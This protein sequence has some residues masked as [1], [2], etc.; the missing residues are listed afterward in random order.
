MGKKKFVLVI[1]LCLA[2]LSVIAMFS[3]SLG[4]K[5]IAFSKVMEVIFGNDLDSIEATIILQRIPRTVFGIL[6]G[7]ALGISGALMQSITRNPIADP[8]ILGV[9]T[10]ASLFVVAGIAFFNITAAYQYIWLAIIGAGL[11]AVF[12]YSVA[13]MGKDGA[14]PLKLALS[15]SAVSIVLGSLVSTIMLPNNRVMEAFRFWQVGSIG[16]ATWENIALISPFMILGFIISM[17]ISGYLNNLALGDEA[18]T[19][20]GTNVVLTRS[21]GALASVLLCGAATALAGPIGFIGL[22]IPHIVRLVFGSEM[23]KM[24]P[25]SFIGSGILLLLSDILGRIIGSPGETEVGI[26][27]AVLGAPIFIFAIRKG[28]VKSL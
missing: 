3:V 4:V 15:G 9:N 26:V 23:S 16:S 25:L 10:G 7:G 22:I 6:A 20:L 2:L 27:T 1:I 8:S 5:R 11:T 12:V 18:A 13:S 19:A 28:R 17:L 14:T 21:V 24:L